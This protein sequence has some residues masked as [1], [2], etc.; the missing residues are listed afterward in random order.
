M[1]GGPFEG[2]YSNASVVHDVA[3]DQRQRPWRDVH[4]AFYTAMLAAKVDSVNAKVMYGA[5]YQF[6]PRWGRQVNLNEIL[7]DSVE[8]TIAQLRAAAAPVECGLTQVNLFLGEAAR[9]GRATPVGLSPIKAGG[10]VIF[11][12]VFPSFSGDTLA[13][14]QRLQSFIESS[15]PP[16]EVIESYRRWPCG[17][18]YNP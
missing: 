17:M 8:P 1:I 18:R 7:L 10:T 13:E 12:P 15:N 6:G 9:Q 4:L 14:F 11:R 5:V 3:C 16:I 2:P